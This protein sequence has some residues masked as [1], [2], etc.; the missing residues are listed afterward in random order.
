MNWL[1]R[2]LTF[3]L[4]L[5]V[6]WAVG[7]V[8]VLERASRYPV[9]AN[10][11]TPWLERHASE[12]IYGGAVN[13]E[14]TRIAL[15]PGEGGARLLLTG[16]SASGGTVAKPLNIGEMTVA[17][18]LPDLLIGRP[19]LTHITVDD[20]SFGARRKRDGSFVFSVAPRPGQND[21]MSLTG[22]PGL[23]GIA[24][25]ATSPEESHSS[26][27][28]SPSPDQAPLDQLRGI[29]L[30]RNGVLSR[31][32]ELRLRG[33]SLV[34]DD[35]AVDERVVVHD[36]TMTFSANPTQARLNIDGLFEIGSSF[37]NGQV[38][39]ITPL[40]GKG[41]DIS[42]TL[43]DIALADFAAYLPDNLYAEERPAAADLRL[44]VTVTDQGQ[45]QRFG[46][47]RHDLGTLQNL[48][49]TFSP[50]LPTLVASGERRTGGAGGWTV[51][52]QT[53][54]AT[55]DGEP[56]LREALRGVFVFDGSVSGSVTFDV[57]EDGRLLD[58]KF[59]A[60][61]GPGLATLPSL[62]QTP[63][64]L[65]G[66]RLVGQF[67]PKGLRFDTLEFIPVINGR[68]LGPAALKLTIDTLAPKVYRIRM[69][70]E[71]NWQLTHDDILALWPDANEDAGRKWFRENIA[72]GRTSGQSLDLDIETGGP[73][74]VVHNLQAEIRFADGAFKLTDGLGY[75]R[76]ASGQISI[77]N[78][79]YTIDLDRAN[80]GPVSAQDSA[81]RIDLRNDLDPRMN[82]RGQF[83]GELRDSLGF[84]TKADIGLKDLAETLPID[85]TDGRMTAAAEM[86]LSLTQPA[87]FKPAYDLK[88]NLQDLRVAN[89]LGGLPVTASA[90][91][92][93]ITPERIATSGA[94]KLGKMNADT[95]LDISL[96]NNKLENLS[97]KAVFS[98]NTE[99]AGTLLGFLP[100]YVK[101][102]VS[103]DL[104]FVRDL[105]GRQTMDVE[106][107]LGRAIIDLSPLP[108]YKPVG[109]PTMATARLSF[110]N[111]GLARVDSFK[112][113]GP[114]LHLM[115]TI[116]MTADG[117]NLAQAKVRNLIIGDNNL[118]SVSLL[119]EREFMQILIE[120]G[121]LDGRPIIESILENQGKQDASIVP[122][123]IEAS[124]NAPNHKPW[125]VNVSGIRRFVVPGGKAFTNIS[126]SATIDRG[127]VI[128]FSLNAK[129]PAHLPGRPAEL[130]NLRAALTPQANGF[131]LL[132]FQSDDAGSLF[133]TL[134]LTDEIRGGV[135]RVSA[136]SALPLPKGGW[137]GSM[138]MLNFSLVDAPI[139]VQLLSLASLTGILELAAVGGLQFTNLTSNFTYGN[140]AL[141]LDDLRMAGPSVGMTT[142]GSIDFEA[143]R[144]ALQGNVTPFNLVSEIA[145]SIPVL[146]QVLTGTDGGGLF[147]AGYKV[148]GPFSDP[149][150]NVNPFQI[151]TPGI[152]RQWFQDIISNN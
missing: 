55:F 141:Y 36:A 33:G 112:V 51:A 23:G 70:V 131:Y 96:A 15:Q 109:Q 111:A 103:G 65:R 34:F 132:T 107:N 102:E 136:N 30:D 108:Y 105:N 46:I 94:V 149:V 98:G 146:G 68:N 116:D 143:K 79:L 75:A 152:Y 8:F 127:A 142:E 90:L 17:L 49:P 114:A 20:L 145:G 3:A 89:Y 139:M 119:N 91:P 39:L 50:L 99:D 4:F 92:V 28:A 81:I 12:Q 138:E 123:T 106:A 35:A 74:T 42:A 140:S 63:V 61:I 9:E 41:V 147:S 148:D 82:L 56:A 100:D 43:M 2:L 104:S 84:L 62:Y 11:L 14:K 67:T 137:L 19:R 53:P 18:S 110:S 76:N 115:G 38:E 87:A 58:L 1:V 134:N 25:A 47:E 88:L 40:D 124:P 95:E 52:I 24:E 101:G 93:R 78:G 48:D 7:V 72:R 125:L 113:D 22:V 10:F 31:F 151:L 80:V 59:D 54:S 130:G 126:L 77:D 144:F 73:E 120:D 5:V 29:L 6:A 85:R 135:V 133:S 32:E 86:S 97:L 21:A 37:S 128:Q 71:N 57:A 13:I 118:A 66:G 117:Q 44:A 16:V 27:V 64:A 26:P 121:Q 122:G 69:G 150:V 129:S 60:A 45:L 83:D